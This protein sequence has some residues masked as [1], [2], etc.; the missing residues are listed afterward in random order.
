LYRFLNN[1]K[2]RV[3]QAPWLTI[4]NEEI[5]AGFLRRT[6]IGLGRHSDLVVNVV[7]EAVAEA[8]KLVPY[9]NLTKILKA[10][11]VISAASAMRY[12]DEVI[13][14]YLA[15][16][17]GGTCFSLTASIV[18]VYDALGIEVYPVLAD[19]H[20]GVD[21]HCGLVLVTPEGKTVLLDPGYLLCTPVTVP[22]ESPVFMDT[23]YNRI[24]LR[25]AG[26]GRLELYTI[27]KTNRKLR[28]TFKMGSV[29]DEMFGNAWERS[30]AFEMMTYPVLTR[31]YRGCHQYLQGTT[32]AV[33]NSR[34]TERT[35]LTPE[36]QIEFISGQMGIHREI[37]KRALGE[38]NYGKSAIAAIG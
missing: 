36:Q 14:D 10:S 13:G 21:T 23:G 5:L 1:T 12:P 18:A 33:R 32:L 6:G 11:S 20:Y 9:E 24:E 34:R 8:F 3:H 16:G 31:Q 38:V 4:K 29:S 27:V 28:L 7:A 17:T 30:F 25:P 19:R 35:V 37:A 26:N 2:K 15:W 22:T